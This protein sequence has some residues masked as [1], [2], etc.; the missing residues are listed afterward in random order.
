MSITPEAID[1]FW[2][3]VQVQT[4]AGCWEWTGYKHKSGY[5]MFRVGDSKHFAHRV[6][7]MIKNGDIGDDTVVSHLC[8]SSECV[9]PLH[10]FAESRSEMVSRTHKKDLVERFWSKV[11]VRG[12][13]EC[14]NWTAVLN[15]DGYGHVKI[16][17][18][19]HGAHRVSWELAHGKI[20]KRMCVCHRCDNPSCVNPNHLFL[21]THAENMRDM[22]E[23]GRAGSNGGSPGEKNWSSVLTESDVRE[24]RRMLNDGIKQREIGEKFGVSR[25]TISAI[26]CGVLWRHVHD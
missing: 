25:S 3:K 12:N 11:D 22:A 1:R 4:L 18:H 17:G 2:D 6:V 5:G 23:K 14:W 21:A 13:D 9:N 20:P 24:I 26:Y 10:L 7:W 8:D 19:H 16:S 15:S